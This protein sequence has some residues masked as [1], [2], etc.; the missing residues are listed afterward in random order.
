MRVLTLYNQKGGVGKTSV[1]VHLAAVWAELGRRVLLLDLDPQGSAS[2]WLGVEDSGAGLKAALLDAV[3]PG[4]KTPRLLDL[5]RPSPSAPGVDLVPAGLQ[6]AAAERALANAMG[7]DRALAM[8]LR[9]VREADRYDVAIIDPPPS[10]A[11]LS[12]SVLFAADALVIPCEPSPVAV[13]ALG[14]VLETVRRVEAFAERPLPVVGVVPVKVEMRSNMGRFLGPDLE[15][16]FPGLTRSGIRDC[17]KLKTSWMDRAPVT[18]RYPRSRSAEDF[19]RLAGELL[20]V[21]R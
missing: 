14:A 20:E 19:R 12:T 6:L 11:M 18:S 2:L 8:L 4:A 16:A 5:V 21:T 3:E 9:Q 1:A 7:G 10:L 15:R 13:H 17:T